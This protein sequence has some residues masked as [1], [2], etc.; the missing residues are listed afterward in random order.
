MRTDSDGFCWLRCPATQYAQ[1]PEPYAR[2]LRQARAVAAAHA[3]QKVQRSWPLARPRRAPDDLR[4]QVRDERTPPTASMASTC[5]PRA[6]LTAH[7]M[8]LLDRAAAYVRCIGRRSAFAPR[9]AG[10]G[11]MP[12]GGAME[13]AA[14]L[15]VDTAPSDATGVQQGSG[16]P[17]RYHGTTTG[18]ARA[19]GSLAAARLLAQVASMRGPGQGTSH[20][21]GAAP[22]RR[23]ARIFRSHAPRRR[24]WAVGG[25]VLIGACIAAFALRPL[26]AAM[27]KHIA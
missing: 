12:R 11:R 24:V 15:V 2:L 14:R 7:T 4:R 9:R 10:G 1:S 5:L 18:A 20:P 8:R 22:W 13:R 26:H 17:C 3:G 21:D 25:G 27:T 16:P 6:A 23:I 19:G